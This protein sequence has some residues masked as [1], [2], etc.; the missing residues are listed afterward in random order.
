MKNVA[1]QDVDPVISRRY[2]SALTITQRGND[3]LARYCYT[4]GLKSSPNPSDTTR[5]ILQ[6]ESDIDHPCLLLCRARH[7][8][9]MTYCNVIM[10]WS[11]TAFPANY[12]DII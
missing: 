4:N 5:Q 11:R 12:H 2:F 10:A 3:K 1:I 7:G 9:Q 6:Q 8:H